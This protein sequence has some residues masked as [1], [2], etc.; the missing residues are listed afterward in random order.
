M[1][2]KSDVYQSPLTKLYAKQQKKVKP[3]KGMRNLLMAYAENDY[4]RIAKLLQ[5]WLQQS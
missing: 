1:K 4:Q 3:K 2:P 5:Y